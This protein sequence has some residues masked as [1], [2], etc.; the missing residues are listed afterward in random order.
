[1]SKHDESY[2]KF[3]KHPEMVED[4]L[5]GFVDA[6]WVKE[7]DF[8]TL[9]K[10]DKEYIVDK[11]LKKRASDLVWRVRYKKEWLYIYLLLE[12]QSKPDPVMALRMMVYTGLL[13]LELYTEGKFKTKG[14]K[15]KIPQ[16][17]PVFPL[18]LYN[19]KIRWH[20]ALDVNDLIIESP[21]GLEPYRPHFRYCLIDEG[22]Y[23]NHNL[24]SLKNLV[25]SLFR[26]E[27]SQTEKDIREVLNSLVKWL[28]EPEQTSLSQSFAIWLTEV[29]L[30]KQY[31]NVKFPEIDTLRGVS[32]MLAETVQGW[33]KKAEEKGE[34]I[35]E[36]KGEIKGKTKSLV[37][38][39]ETRFGQ[40]NQNQYE[41]INDLTDKIVMK[42]M[43]YLFQ[44]RSLDEMFKF[45]NKQS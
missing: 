16:F 26:L 23:T 30:P 33:Y 28:D 9:E 6:P 20:K 40:L 22:I 14:T 19:G 35:G 42:A 15:H 11:K 17:S 1:M 32:S 25:A 5:L 24:A 39:L 4:L 10:L 36:K 31:P 3:F 8:S 27:N 13:Y 44:A 29:L 2:K 7:V 34:K 37:F 43:A 18:V 12:F 41:I 21:L 45:I 38:M